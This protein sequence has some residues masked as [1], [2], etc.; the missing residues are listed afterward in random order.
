VDFQIDEHF[1][2]LT[3]RNAESNRTTEDEAWFKAGPLSDTATGE[4]TL[5]MSYRGRDGEKEFLFD[6][7]EYET[8]QAGAGIT[9]LNSGS[10]SSGLPQSTLLSAGGDGASGT[11]SEGGGGGA[12][13][14]MVVGAV[15][16]TLVVTALLLAAAFLCYRWRRRIKEEHTVRLSVSEAQSINGRSHSST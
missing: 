7:V 11:G 12:S 10:L 8:S 4:H 6:Y 1:P 16:G 13:V 14:Q 9:N 5:V 3:V 15:V 2:V